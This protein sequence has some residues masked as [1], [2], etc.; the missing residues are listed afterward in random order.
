MSSVP[1]QATDILE[2]IYLRLT[3]PFQSDQVSFS[4]YL[5]LPKLFT[6]WF[7]EVACE[8]KSLRVYF[9]ASSFQHILFGARLD[10][11]LL[12][13]LD[14]VYSCKDLAIYDLQLLTNL[15]VSVRT[16]FLLTAN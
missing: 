13:S 7:L 14:L 6:A 15:L 11:H 16:A 1:E 8:M 12:D 5:Y 9:A 3:F 10:L 2:Q 4:I